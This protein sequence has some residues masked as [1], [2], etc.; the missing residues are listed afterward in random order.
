MFYVFVFIGFT[1]VCE[2]AT[3]GNIEIVRHLHQHGADINQEN[4][5][6]R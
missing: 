4:R 6:G 1:P 3:K 5:F 2:A